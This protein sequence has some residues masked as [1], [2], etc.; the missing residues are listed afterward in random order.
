MSRRWMVVPGA[1]SV[2][3]AFQVCAGEVPAPNS[4]KDKVSYAT[5]VDLVRSFQRQGVEVDRDLF[6]KGVKDGLSGGSLLMSEEDINKSLKVFRTEQKMKQ[7]E[8][9]QQQSGQLRMQ[10]QAAETAGEENRKAGEAYLAAN[11]VKEGVVTLPSGLQYKVLKAA[12]GRKP[13]DDDTVECRYRGTLIDGTEFDS[14]DRT[15]QPATFKVTGVIPGWREALKLMP[16]GSKWQ[17][18]IPPHLGYGARGAG[19]SIGPHAT[20]VFELELLAVK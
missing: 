20:L 17:L 7:S 3:L 16:A 4:V 10:R 15:G 8:R 5:G 13:M 11:K 1:V 18:F 6:L 19:R 2:F 9:K 12:D 14:T